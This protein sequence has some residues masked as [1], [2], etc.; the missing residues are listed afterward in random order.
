MAQLLSISTS[1]QVLRTPFAGRKRLS[2]P[3]TTFSV[4]RSLDLIKQY[5]K[6]ERTKGLMIGVDAKK[7]LFYTFY[8]LKVRKSCFSIKKLILTSERHAEHP[9]AG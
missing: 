4:T 8:D 1:K 9:F 6:L 3:K 7:P 5:C 2:D